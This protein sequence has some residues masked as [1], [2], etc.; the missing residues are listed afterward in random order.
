MIELDPATVIYIT[1]PQVEIDAA[2]APP[3]WGLSAI[4][5][6]RVAHLAQR[7]TILKPTGKAAVIASAERKAVETAAPLAA[8]LGALVS[9]RPDT[10]E[11]DRSSTGYLLPDAFEAQADA[12]FAKPSQSVRGWE[13][14]IDAQARIQREVQAVEQDYPDSA[15]VF[16]GH[17]AVGT[18]LYC[19]L[20]GV[21]IDRR[22]DQS[23]GGGNW[24]AYDRHSRQVLGHWA[25]I[26]TLFAGQRA[27]CEKR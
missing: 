13:R 27:G 20:R 25:P 19:A 1:H 26:E 18:L 17:G 16:C 24:F 2:V 5:S 10:H 12:F 21:A 4:G 3:D 23:A 6:A 22:W 15:L 7:L 9:C 14:A 11:N 8:A